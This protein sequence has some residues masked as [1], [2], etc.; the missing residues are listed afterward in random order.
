MKTLEDA[1][2]EA[3]ARHGHA[4]PFRVGIQVVLLGIHC[5]NPYRE[6][7]RGWN[8]YEEGVREGQRRAALSAP[9]AEQ[10]ERDA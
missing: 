10:G 4:S 7:S 3:R 5:E 6:G 1:R 2:E 9:Q 8:S